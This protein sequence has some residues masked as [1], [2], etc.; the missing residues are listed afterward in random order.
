MRRD[1]SLWFAN[2]CEHTILSMFDLRHIVKLKIMR[3]LKDERRASKGYAR[4]DDSPDS[5]LYHA[6]EYSNSRNYD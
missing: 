3:A 2:H 5:I 6:K 1:I 4:T